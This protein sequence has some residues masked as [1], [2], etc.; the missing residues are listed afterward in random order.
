[1]FLTIFN[2]SVDYNFSFSHS[3]K[4]YPNFHANLVISECILT[5]YTELVIEYLES[6]FPPEFC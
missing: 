6:L 2:S 4:F 1:M 3:F 5:R